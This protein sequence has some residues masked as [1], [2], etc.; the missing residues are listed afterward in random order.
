MSKLSEINRLH[1]DLERK[2]KKLDALLWVW[3]DGGCDGGVNRYTPKEL[4]LEMVE[5]A[6]RNTKRL[7][8]WY[9]NHKFKKQ[10]KLMSDQE[11]NE[12]FKTHK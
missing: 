1:K 11:R 8:S 6:E 3:C 10:W 12:W 9:E 7:R 5:T 4:T 2:N